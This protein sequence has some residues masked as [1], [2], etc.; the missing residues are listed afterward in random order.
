M[1]ISNMKNKKNATYICQKEF[2]DNKYEKRKFKLYKKVRDIVI[3][4]EDLEELLI[5]FV[6]YVIKYLKRIL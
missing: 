6:I 2:C 4:Q 3:L 1:K 5:A